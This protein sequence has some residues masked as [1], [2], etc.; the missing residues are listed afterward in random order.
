MVRA[1]DLPAE[2]LRKL[3]VEAGKVAL[4]SSATVTVLGACPGPFPLG[5]FCRKSCQYGH[6]RSV[7]VLPDIVAIELLANGDDT[8]GELR[9]VEMGAGRSV[10]CAVV[11]L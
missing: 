2:V 5:C 9:H 8:V 1:L 11:M 3:V 6:D 4:N 10:S 7:V